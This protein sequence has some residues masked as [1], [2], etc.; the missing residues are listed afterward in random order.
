MRGWESPLVNQ[1]D[2]FECRHLFD[3]G[4]KLWALQFH[5]YIQSQYSSVESQSCEELARV[6][7]VQILACPFA[8][9]PRENAVLA[10][11]SSRRVGPFEGPTDAFPVSGD[12]YGNRRPW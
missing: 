10:I 1:A 11:A 6:Q 7:C 9:N 5:F 2:W 8:S 12:A 4:W 3:V